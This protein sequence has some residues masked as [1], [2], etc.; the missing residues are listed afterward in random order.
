MAFRVHMVNILLPR[1]SVSAF[2]IFR[3]F[4][5]VTYFPNRCFNLGRKDVRF[6]GGIP[7]PPTPGQ[8]APSPGQT[9][10]DEVQDH[11]ESEKGRKHRKG[12]DAQSPSTLHKMFEASAT[13]FASIVILAL[14]GY[15]YHRYYKHLILRKMQL[16]FEPGDPMLELA[17]LDGQ[18][19]DNITE[20]DQQH[21]WIRRVEQDKIDA[22]VNGNDKG[23]YHLLI[24][25]KGTGKSSMILEAMRKIN[26]EGVA[27][28][29]AHADLEIFR[30]R[31][32]K[33]LN[34]KFYEDYI[35]SLFSI[36]GPRDTT[37]LLDIER[38]FNKLE[39][40]ALMRRKRV[41]KPLVLIINSVHLL[42][43]DDD[44]RNLLELIQQRAEQWAASNL[45]TVVMNSDDYVS[46]GY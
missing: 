15:G 22:I 18:R 21:H 20:K 23:H 41:G 11:S 14:A 46:Y 45:V 5:F 40:V 44:G 16:A 39:R 25:E 38:S 34:Y 36:R 7:T 3:P 42:R 30:I 8:L 2:S 32:G 37:A 10:G 12:H 4:P 27:M 28:F 1:S 33:A 29:E 6:F 17:E 9:S 26:G 19:P 31:I 13:T 35:G 24:S 43:D